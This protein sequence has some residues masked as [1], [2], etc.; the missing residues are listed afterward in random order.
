MDNSDLRFKN[1]FYKLNFFNAD[2]H[3]I[4]SELNK[5]NWD[6]ELAH[7]NT[8]DA[9][10]VFYDILTRII[11]RYVQCIKISTDYPLWYS[12][13]TKSLLKEKV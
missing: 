3:D 2:Y 1:S 7:L 12:N 4:C 6:I 10:T 8:D 9:V 13:Y 11:D 5:F